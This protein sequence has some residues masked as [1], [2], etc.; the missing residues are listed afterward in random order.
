VNNYYRPSGFGGFRLFPP[1]IKNL[2]II[3]SVIFLIELLSQQIKIADGYSLYYYIILWFGLLPFGNGFEVWQ[4]ITYQFLHGGFL[5]IIFNMFILWM[6]G[7]EVENL[8]GS[9]RF[10]IFYL[11]AGIVGGLFQLI[12]SP[13]LFG[14][15]IWNTIG[16]SG[17]IMGVMVVFAFLFPDRMI[18]LYFLIP[19]KTKYFIIGLILLNLF[20][21][22]S[23]DSIAHLVH[24]GGAL[25]G[26]VYMLYEKKKGTAY[27]NYF[28]GNYGS[29]SETGNFFG[30]MSQNLSSMFKKKP[31]NVE[32][33]KFYEIK[34]EDDEEI[35]QKEIDKILDK[36]SQ[37]GYQNLTEREKKILFEASKKMK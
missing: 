21:I 34:K 12:L 10:L 2:I 16:A 19:I 37:S 31:K 22:N 27:G 11:G 8:W 30:K 26:L 3:N 20:A 13:I 28:D 1:V 15:I 32:D 29:S 5:H 4:L 23:G 24:I 25:T 36:I 6:F 18:Y 7:I 9:K 17:A 35:D 14:N 33:A